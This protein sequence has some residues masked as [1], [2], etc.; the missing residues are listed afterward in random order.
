MYS[1]CVLKC[2]PLPKHT[3]TIIGQL[4]DFFH[5]NIC[6]SPTDDNVKG[7]G[8]VQIKVHTLVCSFGEV[9]CQSAIDSAQSDHTMVT[10]LTAKM[11]EVLN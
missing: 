7:L 6:T 4:P 11:L 3:W 8:A 9:F 1:Q 5:P 10:R 2:S